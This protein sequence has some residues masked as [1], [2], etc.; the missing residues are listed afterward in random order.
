MDADEINK[1]RWRCRRG[2]K[3]LDLI[4]GEFI[5][6]HYAALNAAE[7]RNFA[8][9]LTCSDPQ[10]LSYFYGGVIPAEPDIASIVE[11]ILQTA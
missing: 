9:L 2:A 4:L 11:R 10:L 7:R 1:L 8:R 6:H 5:T 3:E